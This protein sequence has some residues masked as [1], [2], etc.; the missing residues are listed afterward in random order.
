MKLAKKID[1]FSAALCHK[2][3][4]LVKGVVLMDDTYPMTPGKEVTLK[5]LLPARSTLTRSTA[6]HEINL[7]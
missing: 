6:C 5:L 4:V 3:G 1:G 2:Y 7:S